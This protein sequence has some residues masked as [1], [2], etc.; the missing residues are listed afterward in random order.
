MIFAGGSSLA[1]GTAPAGMANPHALF[2]T[3]L[4]GKLGGCAC[5]R[6]RSRAVPSRCQADV[7]LEEAS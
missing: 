3:P 2:L 1:S 5:L 4:N 6:I 7:P